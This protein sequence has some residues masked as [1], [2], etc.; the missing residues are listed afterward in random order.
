MLLTE[1]FLFLMEARKKVLANTRYALFAEAI[2]VPM[3]GCLNVTIAVH[4]WRM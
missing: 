2:A 3:R 4:H 1:H